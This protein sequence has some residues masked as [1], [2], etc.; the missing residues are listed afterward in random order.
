MALWFLEIR[1]F[2]N[3]P[4]FFRVSEGGGGGGGGVVISGVLR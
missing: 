4:F 2:K 3:M 1:S